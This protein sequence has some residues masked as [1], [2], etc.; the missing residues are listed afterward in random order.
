MVQSGPTSGVLTVTTTSHRLFGALT[1]EHPAARVLAQL[2]ASRQERG[3]DGGLLT[4]M[5][6]CSIVLGAS[7]RRL[8]PRLCAALLPEMFSIAL[9]MVLDGSVSAPSSG[10]SG[11]RYLPTAAPVR[12][13]D[14]R[15]L[16]SLVS[17]VLRP[18]HVAVPSGGGDDPEQLALLLVK[19]FVQSLSDGAPAHVAP[20]DDD[21]ND[22]GPPS[23]PARRAAAFLPGVRPLAVI[24]SRLDASHCLPGVLLDTPRISGAP[25]PR[26]RATTSTSGSAVPSAGGL[27]VALYNVSLEAALPESLDAVLTLSRE[28]GDAVDATAEALLAS[29]ADALVACGVRVLC[30]QQRVAPALSRLLVARGVLPL[31]RLSLRHIGAVRRLSGATPLSHLHPPSMAELGVLGGVEEVHLG[32]R[33]YIQLL[34][35][36]PSTPSHPHGAQPVVT[37]VLCAPN[38]VASEEL[39]A[40]TACALG[41]LG[42]ALRQAR[43]RVLPGAGCFEAL[44][45]STLRRQARPPPA[46]DKSGDE[47]IARPARIAADRAASQGTPAATVGTAVDESGC[48]EETVRTAVPDGAVGSSLAGGLGSDGVEGGERKLHRLRCEVSE[49]LAEVLEESVVAL[50]GGGVAGRE[51]AEALVQANDAAAAH[52]LGTENAKRRLTRAFYGWDV[53]TNAPVEVLRLSYP[54]ANVAAAEADGE[55][56]SSSSSSG[57]EDGDDEKG[58]RSAPQI[59]SARVVELESEKLEAIYSAIEVASALLGVDGVIADTR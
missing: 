55:S 27:P 42:A 11:L 14:L 59:E 24:G 32:G 17:T 50:A 20:I 19:C 7:R 4:I 48:D 5:L 3:A 15:C 41:T 44:M 16:L 28:R 33:C 35:P 37:A 40:V 18:K 47:V 54:L 8:P 46:E 22:E 53:E 10:A 30:C 25:L 21:G 29:F 9:R 6:A 56:S 23:P 13:S 1:I 38:R 36:P 31:P 39:S 45:A 58:A 51:A 26:P 49:L 43:P 2:L 57:A 34:P 12:M 52:E